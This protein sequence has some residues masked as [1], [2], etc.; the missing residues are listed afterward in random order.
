M[1][2]AP[3]WPSMMP[4]P[5]PGSHWKVS[6]PAPRKALSL[7]CWPSRK[8]LPSPPSTV[9]HTVAAEDGVVAGVTGE[10]Q[11]DQRRQLAGGRWWGVVTAAGVERQVRG[12]VPMSIANGA[13]LMRSKRT[14]VPLAVVVN[15]SGPP[16]P[17]TSVVSLPSPPSLRSC[18]RPGSRSSG[19]RR[20]RRR[21]GRRRRHRPGG[22]HRPPRTSGRCRRCR[23]ARRPRTGRG[24]SRCRSRRM[25]LSSPA[26]PMISA[27]GM[28]R[29]GVSTIFERVIAA[30]AEQVDRPGVGHGGDH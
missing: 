21:P 30:D 16:P 17:L 19:R 18:P 25:T 4:P 20:P 13:G 11:G 5:S 14:R 29:P 2:S 12:F 8:S 23:R 7:P 26:P 3:S 15:C 9:V 1:L 6:S 10:V 22:R 24:S 27:F 28:A